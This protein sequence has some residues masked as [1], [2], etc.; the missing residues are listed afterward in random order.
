MRTVRSFL[1]IGHWTGRPSSSYTP[2]HTSVCISLLHSFDCCCFLSLCFHP[3][4]PFP[5]PLHPPFS[6]LTP[7]PPPAMVKKKVDSRIRTLIENGLALHHRSL[8]F[9][10]G[11]HARDQIVNLHYLLSKSSV[12][13]KP[14]VLW[15]YKKDLG[16]TSHRQKRLR[17]MKKDIARGIR[18][19]EEESP[20]EL[21]VNS[22][23]IRYCFYR[24]SD[25]ILGNTYQMLILQDFQALTPNLLARTIETVEGGGIVVLLMKTLSSLT[26]L[27]SMTMD[28]HARFRTESHTEVVGRFNERFLLSLSHCQSCIVLDDELN[29]L[30]I[31]S[32]VRHIQKVIAPTLTASP[33]PSS[34][35]STVVS[36]RTFTT[37]NAKALYDLQVQMRDTQPIGSLLDACRTLDQAKAV[38]TF[39]EAISEKTLRSTVVL[40]AA[41]GRGKSAAL[42]LS[43]A[44]AVSY[45]Y[46]NI[47][48]TAPSPENLRTLFDL[49]LRGFDALDLKEHQHYDVVQSTNP[50]FN[51]A[52]VRINVFHTHRQTI[53]YIQP[54]DVAMLSQAELVVIDEAAAIPLP[55]VKALLGPYLVFM[56]S[57]VNGYEG[58]G[59]SLAL[60]LVKQLRQQS[61]QPTTPGGGGSAASTGGRVLREVQLEEPI[62]YGVDDPIESWLNDLLCLNCTQS[63]PRLTGGVPHPSQCDL[64]YVERDTLFSSHKAS[65]SFLHRMMAL[66]V[67]SHYKNSPNDLQLMSD[68]PAHHLFVL[69]GPR[70]EG[71]GEGG[72]PDIFCVIQV[73]LEGAISKGSVMAGLG[74]GERAAGD[75][76]PWCVSQQYSNAEFAQ[77]SGVRIVR[78]ATHPEVVRMGYATR[79]MQLLGDYYEGKMTSLHENH[80]SPP[81]RTKRSEEAEGSLLTEALAPRTS[82]PPLLQALTDVPPPTLHYVGVSFGLTSS[83]FAFWAKAG[84]LPLY[85]R[86]TPN[87]L[88]GE[89]TCIMLRSINRGAGIGKEMEMK[90]GW[91]NE[92]VGDFHRR[93]VQLLSYQFNAFDSGLALSLLKE[94]QDNTEASTAAEA[95]G[96]TALTRWSSFL[97]SPLTFSDLSTALTEFDLRRLESYADNLVD[98]HLILDLLPWLAGQLFTQRLRVHLSFTQQAILLALGL[99]HKVVEAVGKEL[100]LQV[101]QVLAQFNKAIRKCTQAIRAIAD[102]AQK[103]STQPATKKVRQRPSK[104]DEVEDGENGEGGVHGEDGGDVAE[105]EKGGE[106][107]EDGGV[108]DAHPQPASSFGAPLSRSM[109]AELDSAALQAKAALRGRQ[110]A[111]LSS[112]SLQHFA[113]KGGEERWEEELKGMGE[114]ASRVSIRTDEK[115]EGKRKVVHDSHNSKRKGRGGGGGEGLS[116]VKSS[117]GK[118]RK[119]KQ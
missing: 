72:L 58:T 86:L 32:H 111:L 95:D 107:E 85:I 50:E 73:C 61:V 17:K 55:L 77:L 19:T 57:T 44:A 16:F 76:I 97:P 59:R 108:D 83:L 82:L 10:I 41:R 98:Y 45:G 49:I 6:P 60:K 117:S 67:S 79:A 119:V 100:G 27:Y 114:G 75:L 11:D 51:H 113:I 101:Q 22:T 56:S 116:A 62:R 4:P 70:Q 34:D 24:E 38:L 14:S 8:F 69:L 12:S 9:L 105:E 90:E 54:H 7:S 46:S 64:W 104:T 2:T 102:N 36:T 63:I 53:Q 25:R 48:V 39:T 78:I 84:F 43:I 66:Y 118:K 65:E 91:L 106:D 115:V 42:G 1:R 80:P 112:S 33:S 23:D 89:H 15:A 52:V 110:K 81:I 35:A 37:P 88:T 31:S 92:F 47:F 5:L 13:T 28:V 3:P 40:T 29:I 26:Q 99:Q 71:D 94:G 87:A 74:R 103:R 30:P 21:F 18:Q 93:F 109:D 20:F 68:A 96:A